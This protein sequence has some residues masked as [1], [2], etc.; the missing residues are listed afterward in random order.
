MRRLSLTVVGIA[1]ALAALTACGTTI[2]GSAEPSVTTAASLASLVQ[3]RTATATSAHFHMDISAAGMDI[4][5]N[6]QMRFAGANTVMQM[7]MDTPMGEMDAVLI[8]G[9]MYM[10]LPANLMGE[11]GT[12]KPWVKFDANGTDPV[13]KSLSALVSQ[14]QQNLD[15]TKTLQMIAPFAT[16][17]GKRQDTVAGAPATEYTISVDTKKLL[18]SNLLTP[19]MR[20]M[21][22]STGVHLPDHLNYQ[23]WLNSADLPVKFVV[24]EPV[25]AAGTTQTVTAS[26]TYSDWGKPV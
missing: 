6:G 15:P 2:S 7:D 17:T 14:E 1:A 9:T 3:G 10:K 19:Q 22:N 18:Q 26:M 21:V 8:G 12:G 24:T 11:L 4:G 13:S 20:D 5:G 16:I 25:T 23:M